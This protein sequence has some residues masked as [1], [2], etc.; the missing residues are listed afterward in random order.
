MKWQFDGLNTNHGVGVANRN[1]A[2]NVAKITG[3]GV[4]VLFLLA[5]CDQGATPPQAATPS[6]TAAPQETSASTQITPSQSASQ[7]SQESTDHSYTYGTVVS[8]GKGGKAKR[9]Q[10]SGWSGAEQLFTWTDKT[11][12]VLTLKIP[13]TQ[14][15]LTLRMSLEGL[16]AVGLPFQPVRVL[17]NGKEIASWDVA[18]KRDFTAVIPADVLQGS[19]TLTLTLNIPK[20]ATPA[21]LG[22]NK[23]VRTLGVHCFELEISQQ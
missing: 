11:T 21:S 23:D 9:Y 18:G 22:M 12:A 15:P 1:I 2:F 3:A 7:D 13:S 5:A 20:A 6:E 4:A 8:F 19:D 10:V 16:T 14:S 17:A